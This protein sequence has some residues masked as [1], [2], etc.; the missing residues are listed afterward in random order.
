MTGGDGFMHRLYRLILPCLHATGT[1]ISLRMNPLVCSILFNLVSIGSLICS[2]LC[3]SNSFDFSNTQ[4]WKV[5]K[6]TRMLAATRSLNFYLSWSM[7]VRVKWIH[8]TPWA[9]HFPSDSLFIR[10]NEPNDIPKKYS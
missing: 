6:N 3:R 4:T 5:P 9:S 2:Y 8:D 7:I 10:Y 1:A